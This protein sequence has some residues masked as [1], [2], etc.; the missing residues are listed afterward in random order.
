MLFVVFHLF[1]GGEEV[2]PVPEGKGHPGGWCKLVRKLRSLGIGH[3]PIVVIA[4][5]VNESLV[6]GS[7]LG[8]L[9]KL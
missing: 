4:L 8:E 3:S 9:K 2:H 5:H 6:V 7:E 1:C